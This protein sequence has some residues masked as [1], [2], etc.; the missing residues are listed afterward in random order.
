MEK[1]QVVGLRSV[2][3]KDDKDGREISGVS[4][5]LLLDHDQVEGKMA[6]KVFVSAKKLENLEYFPKVGEEVYLDYDR[7]GK[8]SRFQQLSKA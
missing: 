6:D 8:V 1:V 5:Y 2:S 4:L 3:F 7:Y